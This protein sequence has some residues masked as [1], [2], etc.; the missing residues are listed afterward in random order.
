MQKQRK[1]HRKTLN[2]GRRKNKQ[3]DTAIMNA[4]GNW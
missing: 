1:R 2:T 3:D 4:T